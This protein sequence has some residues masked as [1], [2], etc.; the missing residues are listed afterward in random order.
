MTSNSPI[1]YINTFHI[2]DTRPAFLI[3]LSTIDSPHLTNRIDYTTT[4]SLLSSLPYL[5]PLL[6]TQNPRFAQAR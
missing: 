6:Q 2:T 3:M 4:P 1:T 5:F